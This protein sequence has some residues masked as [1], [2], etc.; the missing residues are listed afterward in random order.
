MQAA[1]FRPDHLAPTFAESQVL[2]PPR[3][4]AFYDVEDVKPVD[5]AT[6]KLELAA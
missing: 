1:I 6:W 5:G 4:N 2:K 3:F